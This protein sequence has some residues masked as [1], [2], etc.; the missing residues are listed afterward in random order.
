MKD[1]LKTLILNENSK[2]PCVLCAGPYPAVGHSEFCDRERPAEEYIFGLCSE[3]SKPIKRSVVEFTVYN[4]T[5]RF[6]IV[7]P[8]V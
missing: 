6:V 4:V 3:V 1:G 2:A 5:Y 8:P 7:Q